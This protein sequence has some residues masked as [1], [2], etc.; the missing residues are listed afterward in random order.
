MVK[1]FELWQLTQ[2]KTIVFN[3]IK[4][5]GKSLSLNFKIPTMVPRFF[6]DCIYSFNNQIFDT[7]QL[8]IVDIDNKGTHFSTSYG[9][10]QCPKPFIGLIFGDSNRS[11]V[12]TTTNMLDKDV[13]NCDFEYK[14][15]YGDF[16]FKAD[17][18]VRMSQQLPWHCF[19]YT[20]DKL[21]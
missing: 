8:I 14:T 17:I 7:E 20:K 11:T 18:A 3:K 15:Q 19:N 16:T 4:N 9:Y 10:G 5:S 1:D 6:H 2:Y 13:Y 12:V 21:N